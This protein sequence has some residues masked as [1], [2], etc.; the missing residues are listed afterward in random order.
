[1]KLAISLKSENT[2]KAIIIT[3]LLGLISKLFSF[4][5]S[6]VITHSFGAEKSTDILLYVLTFSITLTSFSTAISQ[7]VIV[8][9]AVNER[10]KSE[11]SSK[12]LLG[13]YYMVNLV[14]G[15]GITLLLVLFPVQILSLVSKFS[16][17]DLT[18]N[19]NMERII[20]LNLVFLLLNSIII[21]IFGS[22]RMF[23]LPSL[24]DMLKSILIIV[25]VLLFH[26]SYSTLSF[27]AGILIANIMQFVYLNYLLVKKF[28]WKFRFRKFI[29]DSSI[30]NNITFVVIGQIFTFL[31]SFVT[32]FLLSGFNE[33]VYSASN[34]AEQINNIIMVAVVT[35]VSTVLGMDF[36]E[37][38]SK[39]LFSKLSEVFEEYSKVILFFVVLLCFVVS[40][41]SDLIISVLFQRGKFGIEA[42]N[43]TGS[44]LR[45]NVLIIPAI[46]LNS[47]VTRL[48]TAKQIQ[49]IGLVQQIGSNSLMSI[50]VFVLM[51][52]TG[53]TGYPLGRLITYYLFIFV[54]FLIM[55][56]FQFSFIRY[57]DVL[58][59]LSKNIII[60]LLISGL[61]YLPYNFLFK[62][63]LGSFGIKFIYL[64]VNCLIYAGVFIAA[65]FLIKDNRCIL[66]KMFAFIKARRK[67]QEE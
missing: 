58:K 12:V 42:V 26:S 53:Y 28:S 34:Y 14:L 56:R 6:I 38:Y 35:Q 22:Y 54:P 50:L 44:F 23:T 29:F 62:D 3:S 25:I 48:I 47:L 46:I 21:D 27:A 63:V 59:F 32:M 33:G 67:F 51:K 45:I 8:P 61:L 17:Q 52:F 1:M 24:C 2:N 10:N 36:I 19:L 55:M 30:K 11:E 20:V 15:L 37:L 31:N 49:G 40:L 41:N 43:M 65:S 13:N 64:A 57:T 60:N 9:Y 18:Y 7:L 4:L 16:L 66:V 5:Q 39:K